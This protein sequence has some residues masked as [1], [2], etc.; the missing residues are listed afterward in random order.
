MD[1]DEKKEESI[2]K[3]EEPAAERK[4]SESGEKNS[5]KRG[6]WV[7]AAAGIVFASAVIL[8]A[9]F[10][11]S[12]TI[13]QRILAQTGASTAEEAR[14]D[15]EFLLKYHQIKT[16]LE[17]NFLYE[18]DEDALR[19]GMYKGMLESLGDPYTV[20]Y[21][22]E[23]YDALFESMTGTYYGIGVMASQ[24]PESKEISII[25]V[26]PG[27]PAEEEGIKEGDVIVQ[28]D[29]VDVV[30]EDINVTV[31]RIKGEEG[32]QVDVRIYR[33]DDG[34]Y[35]DFT[36]T[37][38]QVETVTVESRMMEEGIGYIRISEFEDVTPSQFSQALDDLIAQ[39]MTSLILDL[40]GNP[41][42]SLT[43][44]LGVADR[45]IP[46]GVVVSMKD[47]NGNEV[48][49]DSKGTDIFEGKMVV[50]IDGN[51]AS[52]SEVLAGAIKDYERGILMGTTSFGKGIVQT[53]L[54]LQD[55]TA[56]KITVQDYYTP[57]GNNIHQ[58]GIEPDVE[59]AYNPDQGEDNQLDAAVEYIKGWE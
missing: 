22:Q 28:V 53:I 36:L 50:L 37:C 34:E 41:G 38:R 17:N 8:I 16:L 20:Y 39:G 31:S 51:S 10:F 15:Q 32:K 47:K 26:F 59:V 9:V 4:N 29:G 57:S 58:K 35:Y 18:V 7:G 21:D 5:F 25:Q 13:N 33:P 40:R 49:Y 11:W 14:E 46:E 24:D 56:V 30:G 6:V 3:I 54:D 55:H 12:S 1:T 19:E 52:A 45:L 27:S 42:G 44:V 2:E 23:E 43:G 48:S